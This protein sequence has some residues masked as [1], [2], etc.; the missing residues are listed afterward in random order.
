[1]KNAISKFKMVRAEE[2]GTSAGGA[3]VSNPENKRDV[4]KTFIFSN[5]SCLG[6]RVIV[7][8]FLRA[9]GILGSLFGLELI[10]CVS[11]ILR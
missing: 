1:M 11:R 7:C 4:I 10:F 6:T 2:V 9:C 5:T 3:L 8:L